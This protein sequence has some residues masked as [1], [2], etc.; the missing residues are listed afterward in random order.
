MKKRR[1]PPPPGPAADAGPAVLGIGWYPDAAE[2]Q[3]A[4]ELFPDG[5]KLHDDYA[6][7]ARSVAEIVQS[8]EG[9]GIRVERVPMRVDAVLRWAERN[10]RAPDAEARSEYAAAQVQLGAAIRRGR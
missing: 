5:D 9:R 1:L 7:Y 2:F 3:R 4:R 8:L 6:A 10:G